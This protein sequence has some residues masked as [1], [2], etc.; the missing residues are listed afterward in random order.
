MILQRVL[1]LLVTK[2]NCSHSSIRRVALI[3]VLRISVYLLIT[4]NVETAI[5]VVR[6]VKGRLITVLHVYLT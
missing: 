1:A 2:I 6:L 3:L 5:L 4:S